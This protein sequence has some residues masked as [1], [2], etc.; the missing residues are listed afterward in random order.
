MN[1]QITGTDFQGNILSLGDPLSLSFHTVLT[2]PYDEI[3]ITVL[4]QE[5]QFKSLKILVDDNL[6]F[7]GLVVS[8]VLEKKLS[9]CLK[10]VSRSKPGYLMEENQINPYAYFQVTGQSIVDTYAKPFGIAGVRLDQNKSINIML[11]S[12]KESYWDYL[13]Q[14]FVQAYGKVPRV[15]RDCYIELTPYTGRSFLL[16]P[17]DPD[18]IRYLD[19]S[20]HY[21]TRTTSKI[22]FYT[23]T[24]DFGSL[25]GES[26]TNSM[27]GNVGFQKELYLHPTR[28][29][30]TERKE[31]ADYL[32]YKSMVD[33]RYVEV[34]LPGWHD[35]EAGDGIVFDRGRGNRENLYVG[36]ARILT[37]NDGITTI[38]RLWDPSR[39]LLA[40]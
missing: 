30:V 32:F 26:Y 27:V 12:E 1:L 35:F 5:V 34:T 20:E 29:W 3:T 19:F 11:V 15:R 17:S 31:Y 40:T 18:G 10:I 7:D 38:L 36:E 25:Y 13:T 4:P 37:G 39:N 9:G 6:F 24:D 33:S 14:F 2:R 21:H 22:Y 23:G 8:Q 16:S 28:S